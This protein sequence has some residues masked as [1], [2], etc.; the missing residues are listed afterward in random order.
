METL[1]V[2][3]DGMPERFHVRGEQEVERIDLVSVAF[4]LV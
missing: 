4:S 2:G 3:S 1:R